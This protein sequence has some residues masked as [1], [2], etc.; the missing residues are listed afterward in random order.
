MIRQTLHVLALAAA[1][2]GTDTIGA[3]AADCLSP[4]QARAAAQQGQVMPMSSLI[5][6]IK[7]A[8]GGEI[9][10]PAQLCKNGGR[11]VYVVNVLQA[12]GQVKKIT[13]DAA[14]GTI[15]GQ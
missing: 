5:G 8:A 12:N 14:S 1:L 9:L 13:V 4:N 10:P 6:N 7:S 15:V 11:Y 3:V 2:A